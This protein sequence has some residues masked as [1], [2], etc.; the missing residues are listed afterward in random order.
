MRAVCIAGELDNTCAQRGGDSR[1][2]IRLSGLAQNALDVAAHS[3]LTY[4][5]L[6]RDAAI[7]ASNRQQLEHLSFTR[8]QNERGSGRRD[9]RSRLHAPGAAAPRKPRAVSCKRDPTAGAADKEPRQ[10]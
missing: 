8:R 5:K 6:E 9:A 1:G 2:A 7:R 4:D 10:P 3:L